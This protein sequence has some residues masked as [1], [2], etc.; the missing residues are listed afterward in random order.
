MCDTPKVPSERTFD[1]K[2][3]ASG[4]GSSGEASFGSGEGSGNDWNALSARRPSP[5]AELVVIRALE[6]YVGM[7]HVFQNKT[8]RQIEQDDLL[9][10]SHF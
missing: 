6:V 1:L 7:L 9:E 3:G 2:K 10:L 8:Y 4:L 5:I